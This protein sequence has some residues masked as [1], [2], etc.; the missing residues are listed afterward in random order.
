MNRVFKSLGV[1]M[2]A[3]VL[4]P[5]TLLAAN[6]T[7]KGNGSVEKPFQ[8]ED[9]DDLKAIGKGVYLYSSNYVLTKDIDASASK[10]EMCNQDGCNGF[11]SIGKN[12]DAADSIIFWGNIDG[13]NHTISNLNIWL[14]CESNVAFISYLGGSVTNLNFDH[15]NVTGRVTESNYVAA[16]AAKQMGSIKNVHV[17]NGFVQG[18][19]YVGGIVGHGTN[20]YNKEAVL[21]EVSFQGTVKG[22]QRVGGIAGQLDMI[23]GL[24]S[25]DVDIIVIKKTAG[26]IVG[27]STADVYRSRSSGTITPG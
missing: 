22:S 9:Y 20:R 17:T 15:I 11:I 21:E 12:K 10:N 25:V 1:I 19:N 24:A 23:V 6:G 18:Q 4:L 13:Q 14:P 2:F 27:Y 3:L 8:I 7:M 5:A 16:V 26:G